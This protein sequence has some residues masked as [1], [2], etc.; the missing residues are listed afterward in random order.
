MPG[1]PAAGSSVTSCSFF[2][3]FIS[4]VGGLDG[5]H[6]G[7]EIANAPSCEPVSFAVRYLPPGEHI[8]RLAHLQSSTATRG[9]KMVEGYAGHL[10]SQGIDYQARDDK[11]KAMM[12]GAPQWQAIANDL[13]VRYLF[14]GPMEESGYPGSTQP[15]K[16]LPV[17]AAGT[18]GTIYDLGTRLCPLYR[19]ELEPA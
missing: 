15:W 7:L 18:W 5:N 14:W 8:R 9:R 2:S 10:F 17:V 1:S 11:L 16:D 4:L 19:N 3:G 12:M 6:T 13:N